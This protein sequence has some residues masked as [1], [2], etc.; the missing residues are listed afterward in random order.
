MF[1]GT[2]PINTA[3]RPWWKGS[4]EDKARAR[5]YWKKKSY[6]F[7][8]FVVS[9]PFEEQNVPENPIRRFVINQSIYDVIEKSIT[10]PDMEDN[11][12]DF[13]GGTDFRIAKTQK[14]E[15]ANYS[16]SNWARKPRS[17]TESEMAAIETHGT[18]DLKQFLG[19]KPDSEE[20]EAIKLMFEMSLA[21]E[22]YDMEAFGKWFKPYGNRGDDDN[23]ST[24]PAR[25]VS[26]P[27]ATPAREEAPAREERAPAVTESAA[28]SES[29]SN[30]ADILERIRLRTQK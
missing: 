24:A 12:T 8:G 16:S 26:R 2:C 29:K 25:T 3:I 7:Q 22:P 28:P 19:R 17:L 11:P 30:P 20:L 14:G 15:W 6:L 4:D 18:H 13:V 5:T 21:D 10:D 23:A 27:A 1:G 9:S